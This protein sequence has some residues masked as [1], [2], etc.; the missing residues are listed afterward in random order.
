V[1]PSKETPKSAQIFFG[2]IVEQK[3]KSGS[4]RYSVNYDEAEEEKVEE[5]SEKLAPEESKEDRPDDFSQK[6]LENPKIL[7]CGLKSHIPI[8]DLLGRHITP[9]R[10]TLK[11]L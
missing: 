9:K 11:P 4:S 10:Y 5:S 2:E 6:V 8:R 7:S 3:K 1:C